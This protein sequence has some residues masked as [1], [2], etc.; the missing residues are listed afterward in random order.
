M[1]VALWER[2]RSEEG[3]IYCWAINWLTDVHSPHEHP[4]VSRSRAENKFCFV[5]GPTIMK[6]IM[7]RG[8]KQRATQWR[9][10]QHLKEE[11]DLFAPRRSSG[12]CIVKSLAAGCSSA[13]DVYPSLAPSVILRHDAFHWNNILVIVVTAVGTDW[14]LRQEHEIRE[15]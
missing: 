12:G 3:S 9:C 8:H 4:K 2:N 14:L 7:E 10:Q 13:T 11:Q 5:N 1:S 15:Q 6:R